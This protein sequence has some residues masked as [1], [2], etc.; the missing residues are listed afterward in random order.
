MVH[1]S[2]NESL[3]DDLTKKA[4]IQNL[5]QTAAALDRLWLDAA[6]EARDEA[7]CLAEASQAVHRALIALST[8]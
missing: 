2:A 3:V 1:Q 4:V 8:F 7:L 6:T 5:R